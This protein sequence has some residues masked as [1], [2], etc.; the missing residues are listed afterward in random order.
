VPPGTPAEVVQRLNREINTILRTPE[1][2][3]TLQKAGAEPAGGS[4]AQFAKVARDEYE[5]W[6]AL[7]Q[8]AK[9][10]AE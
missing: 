9:I 2:I 5:N 7:I 6:K 3:D 4:P 10:K 8:R 1:V